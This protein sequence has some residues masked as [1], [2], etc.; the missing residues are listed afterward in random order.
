LFLEG[1]GLPRSVLGLYVLSPLLFDRCIPV[2][3]GKMGF[4]EILLLKQRER[5]RKREREREH[6][7]GNRYRS[8]RKGEVHTHTGPQGWWCL[9]C[10][11]P[12]HV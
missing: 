2:G 5:E 6:H 3:F 12:V 7:S 11:F 4:E 9:P 8:S 10:L 1:E